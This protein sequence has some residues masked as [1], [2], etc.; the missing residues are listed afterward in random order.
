LGLPNWVV[1]D[2]PPCFRA[3][4]LRPPSSR[5]QILQAYR[6][7]VKHAHPDLG[8]SRREFARLQRHFE[9]AM[10]LASDASSSAD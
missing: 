6:A 10:R 8:G 3:L 1:K 2:T 4:G 7:R 5:D 9:Q